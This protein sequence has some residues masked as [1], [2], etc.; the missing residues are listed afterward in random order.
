MRPTYRKPTIID[1]AREAGVS[2]GSA[3]NALNDVPVVSDQLREKVLAAAERLQYTANPLA[4]TLRRR[5]SG[6]IAFCTTS[7][8]TTYLRS[9]ADAL[10]AVTTNNGYELV[11]ILTHG[12]PDQEFHRIRNQIAR[13]VDGLFLV[14]GPMPDKSL[15]LIVSKHTPA[16]VLDR[17]VDDS[18]FSCVAFDNDAAMRS[19]ASRLFSMGHRE[20]L[21]VAQNLSVITTRQRIEGLLIEASK[22][23]IARDAITIV[24]M[25]QDP[26]VYDAKL[27]KLLSGSQ[28]PTAIIT[29]NSKVLVPTVAHL[30][31]R[32]FRW[33]RDLSLATFDDPEWAVLLP[34]AVTTVSN[35]LDQ[36]AETAWSVLS[37][38]IQ[39]ITCNREC[40]WIKSH[41]V[42]RNSMGEP[43]V[44]S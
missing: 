9:L 16:V 8:N 14:P 26:A 31:S 1:V 39:N 42:I 12:D 22:A 3:S 18:R 29:G 35:D 43:P 24:Q 34:D 4:Q 44:S 5:K 32:G 23:G 15:N 6:I 20:I 41:L 21:F 11:Q 13:Q 40:H 33:P 27:S 17:I 25:D 30:Q 19:I 10:D 38:Q 7:A 2:V 28:R 36:M 37:A